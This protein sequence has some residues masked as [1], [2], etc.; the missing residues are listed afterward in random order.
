MSCLAKRLLCLICALF[1]GLSGAVR[2]GQ[3]DDAD[4][5]IAMV[6]CDGAEGA[7]IWL[8]AEGNPATPCA[9]DTCSLCVMAKAATLPSLPGLGAA[10][11]RW[12]L[13]A[14]SHVAVNAVTVPAIAPNARAPPVP[15]VSA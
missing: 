1:V 8:D 2:A 15:K 3:A 9:R 10:P 4:G 13:L 6:L 5:L 11:M 7:V 12:T 14:T